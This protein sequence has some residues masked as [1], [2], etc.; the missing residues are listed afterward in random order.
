MSKI[1]FFA[2]FNTY[3]YTGM[4]QINFNSIYTAY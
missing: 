4:A 2:A 1:Y 3:G